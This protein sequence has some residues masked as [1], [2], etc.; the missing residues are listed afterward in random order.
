[1]RKIIL[2]IA[3]VILISISAAIAREN[4]SINVNHSFLQKHVY[5]KR[6]V[7]SPNGKYIAVAGDNKIKIWDN[8]GNILGCF[9]DPKPYIN[10]PNEFKYWNPDRGIY[11]VAF[12]PDN[13]H[14]AVSVFKRTVHILNLSGEIVRTIRVPVQK[15]ERGSK[16]WSTIT[17]IAYSPDGK[18]LITF[19]PEQYDLVI[20]DSNFRMEQQLYYYLYHHFLFLI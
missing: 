9:I 16:G 14:V 8:K 3:A 20:R 12:L 1:M 2:L 18:R 15:M 11:A 5:S 10:P 17:E 6:P 13:K 7:V 4:S 19:E